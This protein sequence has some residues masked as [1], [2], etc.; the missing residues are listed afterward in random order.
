M[1]CVGCAVMKPV[2]TGQV[3]KISVPIRVKP[4]TSGVKEATGGN[5]YI[6]SV[7]YDALSPSTHTFP[8]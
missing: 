7:E 5:S 3:K 8:Y 1:S 2:G 6:L 4:P